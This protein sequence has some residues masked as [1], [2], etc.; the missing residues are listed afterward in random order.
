MIQ[1][2]LLVLQDYQFDVTQVPPLLS[3]ILILTLTLCLHPLSLL[4]PPLLL[5]KMV[6]KLAIATLKCSAEIG[7]MVNS[8]DICFIQE[9]WL[10]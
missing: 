2:I 1:L 4:P 6:T 7:I 8:L 9:H 3:Y 10:S 5:F